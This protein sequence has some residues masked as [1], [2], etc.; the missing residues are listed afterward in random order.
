LTSKWTPIPT[1]YLFLFRYQC[2]FFGRHDDAHPLHDFGLSLSSCF[3]SSQYMF[4]FPAS[5]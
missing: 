1:W 4:L 5:S 3:P 2:Y